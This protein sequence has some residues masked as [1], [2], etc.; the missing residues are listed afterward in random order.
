MLKTTKV[1]K[2]AGTQ[3]YLSSQRLKLPSQTFDF[4]SN[5]GYSLFDIP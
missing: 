3:N 2:D 4:C 5:Q 1:S